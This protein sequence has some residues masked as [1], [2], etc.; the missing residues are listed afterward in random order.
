[1]TKRSTGQWYWTLNAVPT[2][3]TCVGPFPEPLDTVADALEACIGVL[4]KP[5]DDDP[6]ELCKF[7]LSSPTSDM[8]QFSAVVYT[9]ESKALDGFPRTFEIAPE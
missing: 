3:E 6:F 4:C 9:C 1:M 7:Q 8:S 2:L 5:L